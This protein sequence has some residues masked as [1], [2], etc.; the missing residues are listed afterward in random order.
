MSSPRAGITVEPVRTAA[1]LAAARAIRVAVFVEE[2]GIPPELDDDGLDQG[3]LHVLALDGDLPV[4]TGRVVVPP[5]G[6]AVAARIAVIA[7]HR[8]H[9]LGPRL[10]QALEDV[11]RAHGARTVTLEPHVHLEAFYRRLGYEVTAGSHDV[12][13]HRLIT[14]VK[15]L[16]RA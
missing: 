8:K 3:A 1:E 7:S 16:D 15:Q 4:G 12:G 5:D 13:A 14:M 9:G 11:A 2:Q 10:V 6:A